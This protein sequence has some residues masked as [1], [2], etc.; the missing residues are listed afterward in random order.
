MSKKI[1]PWVAFIAMALLIAPSLMIAGAQEGEDI[2][3]YTIG[4]WKGRRLIALT[5]EPSVQNMSTTDSELYFVIQDERGMLSSIFGDFM[6]DKTVYL[7]KGNDTAN[8]TVL[9]PDANGIYHAE[10]S[11]TGEYYIV[12]TATPILPI[13]IIGDILFPSDTKTI[14][15][16]KAYRIPYE[17]IIGIVFVI[18]LAGGGLY[19]YKEAKK[20]RLREK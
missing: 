6:Y 15:V 8:A 18:V 20:R 17:L 10:F 12:V 13:P 3:A 11:G 7:V 19:V 14:A 5:F 16:I 1:K 2:D 4:S 9:E